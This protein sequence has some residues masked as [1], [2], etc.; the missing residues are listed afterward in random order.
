MAITKTGCRAVVRHTARDAC[1]SWQ[2]YHD[3][4]WSCGVGWNGLC[5]WGIHAAII[6]VVIV[7]LTL[8]GNPLVSEAGG[9]GCKS[10]QL[11]R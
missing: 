10:W 4:W 11:W 7:S 1:Q 8:S 6:G 2:T 9:L 5:G 3:S